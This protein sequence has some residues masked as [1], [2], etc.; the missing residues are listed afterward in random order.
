MV[1]WMPE[2]SAIHGAVNAVL[3][4]LATLAKLALENLMSQNA[5]LASQLITQ[6]HQSQKHA[7]MQLITIDVKFVGLEHQGQLRPLSN[8]LLNFES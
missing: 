8:E 3:L 6:T 7:L 2:E 5:K 1:I 4:E